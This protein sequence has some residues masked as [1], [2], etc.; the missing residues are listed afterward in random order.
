MSG[1][2]KHLRITLH[3]HYYIPNL[4]T[5]NNY[6]QNKIHA[7]NKPSTMFSPRSSQSS[8][9]NRGHIVTPRL[10]NCMKTLIHYNFISFDKKW[11][12]WKFKKYIYV[13]PK[14]LF[15]TSRKSP[16]SFWDHCDVS[17][18]KYLF[19]QIL[20]FPREI[21]LSFR[22]FASLVLGTV[23]SQELILYGTFLLYE[24]NR[25]KIIITEI[26]LP[27]QRNRRIKIEKS[28]LRS[29]FWRKN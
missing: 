25:P 11:W 24:N 8:P 23:T 12:V 1:T 28:C 3:K 9:S 10:N 15:R 7:R 29:K 2:R 20:P 4:K 18:G 14:K 5:K 27:I 26:N 16:A 21:F 22:N 19:D 13:F 6:S 17:G